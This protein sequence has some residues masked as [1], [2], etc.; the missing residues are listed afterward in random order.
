MEEEMVAIWTEKRK[1]TKKILKMS[2]GISCFSVSW[3]KLRNP[4]WVKYAY[5]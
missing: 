5:G 3:E 2:Y 1:Q 4:V